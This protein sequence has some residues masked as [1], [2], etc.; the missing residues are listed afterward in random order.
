MPHKVLQMNCKESAKNLLLFLD[1]KSKFKIYKET[2]KKE[3]KQ[4]KI[5]RT[6]KLGQKILLFM[7]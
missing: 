6:I 7:D 4:R 2:L 5:D 3:Q 1:I